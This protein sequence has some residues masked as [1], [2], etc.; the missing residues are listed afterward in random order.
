MLALIPITYTLCDEHSTVPRL[1]VTKPF[2]YSIIASQ[3]VW[4]L[5]A[6]PILT[7]VAVL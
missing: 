7:P 1:V 2:C 3:V 4:L 5:F 6:L